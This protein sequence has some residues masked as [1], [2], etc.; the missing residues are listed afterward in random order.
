VSARINK[1]PVRTKRS[2]GGL[3]LRG[4]SNVGNQDRPEELIDLDQ[5]LDGL[6]K[7]F[8]R[9]S[10]GEVNAPEPNELSMSREAFLL[11]MPGHREGGD[12]AVKIVTV[13]EDNHEVGVPSHLAVSIPARLPSRISG[14]PSEIA[15]S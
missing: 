5:L 13:F 7:G 12:M 10:A 14:L 4:A 2:L 6:E 8:G 3:L 9:L 15:T 1:S 11:S